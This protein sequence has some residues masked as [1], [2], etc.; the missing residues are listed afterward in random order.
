MTVIAPETVAREALITALTNEFRPEQFAVKDDK[1]HGSVGD[2]GTTIGVY[3]LKSQVSSKDA[4][5]AEYTL[6]VQFYGAYKLETNP[7]QL[8]SPKAIEEYA[9]RFRKKIKAGIDPRTGAVWYFE[10][11]VIDYPDDPTGNK[12]RFEA[13]VLARGNNTSLI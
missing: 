13:H 11:I 4:Q 7:R 3:P 12:T 8:V 2:S 5:M 9:E 1:L 6:V 10:L